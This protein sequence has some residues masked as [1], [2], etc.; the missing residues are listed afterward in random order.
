[1]ADVLD[2]K[3]DMVKNGGIVFEP[4]LT[5]LIGNAV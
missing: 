4:L 2:G 3:R 5:K 1:M